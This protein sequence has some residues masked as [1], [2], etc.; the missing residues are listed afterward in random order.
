[1]LLD[2]PSPCVNAPWSSCGQDSS[3]REVLVHEY[4]YKELATHLH[5]LTIQF[6]PGKVSIVSYNV[7]VMFPMGG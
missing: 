3:G 4:G 6:S 5:L 7:F 2:E 1:M